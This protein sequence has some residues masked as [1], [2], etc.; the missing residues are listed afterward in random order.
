MA[1]PLCAYC[2]RPIHSDDKCRTNYR[3][4][5]HASEA[6]CVEELRAALKA[7]ESA[8]A[9]TEADR[10]RYRALLAAMWDADR[11]L[12]AAAKEVNKARGLFA[13][14]VALGRARAA[15]DDAE[16]VR[17]AAIDAALAATEE[18]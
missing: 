9:S 2:G 7:S 10:D 17:N 5:C 8:L 12:S 4:I 3:G 16:D 13:G 18:G 1:A 11:A 14:D 6:T 15:L